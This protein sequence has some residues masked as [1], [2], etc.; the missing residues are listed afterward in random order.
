MRQGWTITK[1][2]KFANWMEGEAIRRCDKV[3]AISE[4]I[5]M[6]INNHHT[7]NKENIE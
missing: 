6:V 7:I 4:D 1:D 3:I 2:L 5:K